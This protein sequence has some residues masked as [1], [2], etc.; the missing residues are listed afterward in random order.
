MHVACIM[1]LMEDLQ[2][3]ETC[4]GTCGKNHQPGKLDQNGANLCNQEFR[5]QASCVA[6]FYPYNTDLNKIW[7]GTYIYVRTC[8]I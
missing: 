4:S 7:L 2:Y 5:I 1:F 3:C 6:F 8:I